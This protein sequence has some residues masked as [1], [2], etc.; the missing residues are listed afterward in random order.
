MLK[1]TWMPHDVRTVNAIK[2]LD[3]LW[4]G[5]RHTTECHKAKVTA[6]TNEFNHELKDNASLAFGKR[7]G[8]AQGKPCG[9]AARLKK[10]RVGQAASL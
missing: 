4:N 7:C 2:K 1:T 10:R 3:L 6:A 9:Q 8:L 5:L